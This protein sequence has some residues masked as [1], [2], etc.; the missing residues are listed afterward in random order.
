MKILS[1][2]QSE[3]AVSHIITCQSAFNDAILHGSQKGFSEPVIHD[4]VLVSKSLAELAF[5]VGG[6]D[7]VTALENAISNW[8]PRP[9]PPKENK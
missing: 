7:G 6:I 1:K 2:N 4:T 3:E 8:S 9:E 5:L